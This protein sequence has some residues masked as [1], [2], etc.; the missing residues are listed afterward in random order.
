MM[1]AMPFTTQHLTP[2]DLRLCPACK[3]PAE[4]KLF[5]HDDP[6]L[7]YAIECTADGCRQVTVPPPEGQLR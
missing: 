6:P 4:V 2:R 3:A 5:L 7:Y 1:D